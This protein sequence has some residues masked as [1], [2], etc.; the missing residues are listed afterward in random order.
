MRGHR[1]TTRARPAQPCLGEA[2]AS[3]G[4]TGRGSRRACAAAGL[5]QQEAMASLVSRPARS[6]GRLLLNFA[7]PP[8]CAGCSEVI[9]EVGAFCAACW[10]KMEWLGNGGCQRC[11]LPLAGTEIDT[12]GR[13]LADPPRLDRIRAAVAYDE[14]PRSIALRL[15]YGR[16]VALART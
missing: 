13:C 12:C 9:D 6:I 11:G 8:R 15:K 7:L 14:L 16:K 10:G 1:G 2:R 3:G 4:R 5:A